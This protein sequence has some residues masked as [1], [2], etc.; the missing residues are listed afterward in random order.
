MYLFT[1]PSIIVLYSFF[2]I[3]FI[4]YAIIVVPFLPLHS[5]PPCTPPPTHIPPLSSCSWVIHISSLVSTLPILF[6]P[7]PCL[8]STY[9][10]CFLFPVLSL[11][12]SLLPLPADNPPCDLHFCDYVTVLVVCLVHFWF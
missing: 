2:K 11:P 6:L 4:D 3:Y 7:S 8:F 9:Q 5:P 10:L 12:F 1:L